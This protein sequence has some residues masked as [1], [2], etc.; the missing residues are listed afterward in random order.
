MERAAA[1]LKNDNKSLFKAFS[2]Y[3]A[4]IARRDKDIEKFR[5]AVMEYKKQLQRRVEFWRRE[6]DVGRAAGTD[7]AY[8]HEDV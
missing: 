8:D 7:S 4:A 5:A 3:K 1:A 6:A 2:I